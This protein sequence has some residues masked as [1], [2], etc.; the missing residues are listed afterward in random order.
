MKKVDFRLMGR[1]LADCRGRGLEPGMCA[2]LLAQPGSVCPGLR[3]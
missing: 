2:G 3:T 1:P